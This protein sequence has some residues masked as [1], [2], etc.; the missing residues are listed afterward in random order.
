MEASRE[1][2]TRVFF[3][4]FVKGDDHE[5]RKD[6]DRNPVP[7]ISSKDC[8]FGTGKGIQVGLKMKKMMKI[9]S[10]KK[11]KDENGYELC[12]KRI[13]MGKKCKPIL[14]NPLLYDNNGVL[15]P[16]HFPDSP[17]HTYS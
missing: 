4:S 15:I 17:V 14:G 2:L 7:A 9:K 5:Q 11:E 13:L 6:E 10:K 1:G 16:Q 8:K 12:K 3:A